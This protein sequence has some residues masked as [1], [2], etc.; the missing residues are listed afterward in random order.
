M[1]FNKKR[2]PKQNRG[3][4]ENEP[5]DFAW[6]TFIGMNRLGLTEK[7]VDQM[8]LG[9]WI[10]LYEAYKVIYNFETEKSLYQLEDKEEKEEKKGK[11]ESLL[12]L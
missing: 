10:D 9:Q 5:I 3:V 2:K 7:R 1:L 4:E 12:D 8:Y 11:K 6:V